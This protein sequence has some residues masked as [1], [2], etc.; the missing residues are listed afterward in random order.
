MNTIFQTLGT[1]WKYC[2]TSYHVNI[3]DNFETL[4]LRKGNK[5]TMLNIIVAMGRRHKCKIWWEMPKMGG[6]H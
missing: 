6:V 1:V 5:Y 2:H 4:A 3:W